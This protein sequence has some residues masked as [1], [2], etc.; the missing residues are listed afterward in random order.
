VQALPA[1]SGKAQ[2][3]TA[4]GCTQNGTHY[5][6]GTVPEQVFFEEGKHSESCR[7]DR[8]EATWNAIEQET[9]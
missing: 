5:P 3:G 4:R 1:V 6:T 8:R 7:F 9:L 2:F